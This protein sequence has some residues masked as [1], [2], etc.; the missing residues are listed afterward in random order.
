LRFGVGIPDGLE[1]QIMDLSKVFKWL[2]SPSSAQRLTHLRV[3]PDLV[4]AAA[5]MV[6]DSRSDGDIKDFE[7]YLT[8]SEAVVAV[9]QGRYLKV[10]GL[11]VLTTDRILFSSGR[12]LQPEIQVWLPDLGLT[13]TRTGSYSGEL[14]L[15]VGGEQL[16]IDKLLGRE[17]ERIATH[18]R[19]QRADPAPFTPTDP[20]ERLAELRSLRDTGVI[21]RAEFEAERNRLID[22]I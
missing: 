6:G 13:E 20:L 9:A 15:F 7:R 4:R 12:S 18:L 22:E 2:D 21:S 8:E 1:G 16:V 19:H 5:E 11:L 17:N 3:R 10:L 14:H